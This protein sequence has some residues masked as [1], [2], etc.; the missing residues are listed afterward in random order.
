MPPSF[1]I[2][3][4][5]DEIARAGLTGLL[6]FASRAT[7]H[8]YRPVYARF[9]GHLQPGGRVLDWGCGNGH[10]SFFLAR[11]GFDVT[12]YSFGDVPQCLE[13]AS[14]HRHVQGDPSDPRSLPFPDMSFDAVCG[15]GVLEHVHETGGGDLDSL[16]EIARILRP[17]GVFAC[18]HL[19]ARHGWIEPAGRMLG[20]SEHFHSRRYSG[21]DIRNLA[22]AAGFVLEDRWRYNFLPRNQLRRLP[23]PLKDTRAG[24]AA[25]DLVDLAATALL[26]PFTQNHGFVAARR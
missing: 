2:D 15:I 19:P 7:M 12:S 18:A 26:R 16:K 9:L 1:D 5:Y 13:G 21:R 22:H 8:Q 24:A 10:F 3:A 6:Q 25:I 14:G 23:A 11:Q 4:F 17:G 20:V